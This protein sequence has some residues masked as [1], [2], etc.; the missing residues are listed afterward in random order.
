MWFFVLKMLLYF[1]N[2]NSQIFPLTRLLVYY[3][4]FAVGFVF[5]LRRTLDPEQVNVDKRVYLQVL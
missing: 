2:L 5:K 3:T 1:S 4:D